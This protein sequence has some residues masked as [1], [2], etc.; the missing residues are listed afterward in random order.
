MKRK[1]ETK[2]EQELPKTHVCSN[3]EKGLYTKALLQKH[4]NSDTCNVS[5]KK[6]ECDKCSPSKWF[7]T[8]KGLITHIKKYHT[9]EIALFKCKSCEK[10]IG[11][12][13]AMKRHKQWHWDVEE[14]RRKRDAKLQ[15][16]KE[17]LKELERQRE[18]ENLK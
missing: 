4:L 14:K 13:G 1:H 2:E 5:E 7:Q 3:C 6:F 16:E 18:R 9:H 8:D 17:K 11:S 12:K 15:R 10:L